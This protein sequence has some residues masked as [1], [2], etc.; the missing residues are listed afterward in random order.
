MSRS[1]GLRKYMDEMDHELKGT[2]M[3]QSFNQQVRY[4]IDIYHFLLQ[5]ANSVKSSLERGRI[6]DT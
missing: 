6:R 3:G 1:E 4:V 5:C 2:S